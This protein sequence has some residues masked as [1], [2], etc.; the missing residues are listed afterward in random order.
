MQDY[1]SPTPFSPVKPRQS[2]TSLLK[3]DAMF[4]LGNLRKQKAQQ[5]S[6]EQLSVPTGENLNLNQP[7]ESQSSAQFNA[8]G[9]KFA[10]SQ[11]FGNYNPALYGGV[12]KGARHWGTDIATPKGTKVYAPISGQ[13]IPGQDNTFGKFV[14][15]LGDDGIVYQFSHL[16]NAIPGGRVNAGQVIA[17]TG[18]SGRSTGAHLDIMTKRGNNYIDPQSLSTI[19]KLWL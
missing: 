16:S 4:E 15:V 8:P 6:P 14:R 5:Q 19:K 3:L 17:Q 12:T 10:V 1:T 7:I 11:K 2:L 9:Q 13:V 18:N